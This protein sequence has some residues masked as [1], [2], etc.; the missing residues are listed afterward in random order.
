MED[1]VID[2]KVGENLRFMREHLEMSQ[3]TLGDHLEVSYQQVQKYEKGA[4]RISASKLYK[5]CGLFDCQIAFFFRGL[6][7]S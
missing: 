6:P 7:A 5:A 4:N 3:E 1:R 2:I